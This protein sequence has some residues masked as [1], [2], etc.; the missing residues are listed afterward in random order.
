[1][2]SAPFHLSLAI[3]LLAGQLAACTAK[4]ALPTSDAQTVNVD[5]Q[6][7]SADVLPSG[8]TSFVAVVTG[9][10]DTG[11]V[12]TIEEAGGGTVDANGLYVAPSTTGVFH[13]LATSRA[14]P[15][16]GRATVNVTATPTI[17]VT[18][19][20]RTVSVSSLG[21][22]TFAANV[23]GT[24]NTAVAWSVSEGAAGGAITAGG[25][26]TAPATPGTYHVVAK[27]LADPTKTDT[28]PVIVVAAG[29]AGQMSVSGN[30]IL[31]ACGNPVRLV[32]VDQTFGYGFETPAYDPVVNPGGGSLDNL[33]DIMAQSGANFVRLAMDFA[34]GQPGLARYEQLIQRAH[35]LGMV[36][37]IA[38]YNSD[39]GANAYNSPQML[40]WWADPATQAFVARN[41][42]YLLLEAFQETDWATREG[43]RDAVIARVTYIR[44]QGYTQPIIALAPFA[45]RDLVSLLQ[46]GSAIQ[47]ADPLHRV[48]LDWEAYWGSASAG[49]PSY[50][51]TNVDY[52]SNGG[53]N[54]MSD[55]TTVAQAVGIASQ[56]SFPILLDFDYETDPGQALWEYSDGITAA[57]QH[58]MSWAWWFF[59]HPWDPGNT[60]LNKNASGS[61]P[62]G[63]LSNLTAP[64]ANVVINTNP[65][66]LHAG[67]KLTCR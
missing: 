15:L 44:N 12:W 56:Q 23:A 59:Y 57:A 53:K 62:G 8:S 36:V 43:W 1:M 2:R 28:V 6:P 51:E 31:D 35:S 65:N 42:R 9:S 10:V 60:L 11:V 52:W 21:T 45:G 14:A 18:I 27:S 47:A 3:C 55:P 67:V 5:V 22:F 39:L 54:G 61:T 7:K 66:G 19:A 46:Y 20:Q 49:T 25:T 50:Y 33:V 37:S 29:S 48:I 24:S 32:G 30:Q 41:S 64:F 58:G 38:Y 40:A 26:Y 16:A 34:A 63:S 4:S 13:V 17:T